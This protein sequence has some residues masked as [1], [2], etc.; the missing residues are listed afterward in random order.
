M[1]NDTAELIIRFNR[2]VD[3]AAAQSVVA[4]LGGTVRR[5]MRTDHDDE[6]MLLVKV[7]ADDARQRAQQAAGHPQV[8]MV[9]VN[10]D[11]F[12]IR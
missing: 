12:S 8:S 2:G 7:P 4:Q 9:E 10:S 1:P 6:V 11:G 3:E 5:R